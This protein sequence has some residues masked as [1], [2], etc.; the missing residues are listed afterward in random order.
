MPPKKTT[1]ADIPNSEFVKIKDEVNGRWIECSLCD[2]VIKV[3]AAYGFTEWVNHC[4]STK[5]SQLV[6]NEHDPVGMHQLTT[7]FD[8]NNDES[9][10]TLSLKACPFK[11]IKLI[12]PCPGFNYGKNP[13]LLQLYNKYKRQDALN[14]SIFIN[15]RKGV[16]SAHS[17]QCSNEAVTTRHGKCRDKRACQKCFEFSSI[18]LVKDR[19]KR[20]ER[21]FHIEQHFTE[22]T[23]SKTG[24]IEVANFLRS[25]L[26]N[27]SPAS[28][29]LRERCI[30]YI[31]HQ[32]WIEQNMPMC[33]K[34]G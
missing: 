12:N 25:N 33:W 13:E 22:P 6:T 32:D 17:S 19:V 14:D 23:A 18:Q 28:L 29:V 24:Y 26:T 21:I 31:S 7:Y 5:H 2:V 30:K 20:T 1:W 27:A 8:I 34:V 3:R 15:C 16:W 4:S 10:S 9:N 11:K